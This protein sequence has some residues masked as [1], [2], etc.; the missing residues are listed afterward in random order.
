MQMNC[1]RRCL[2]FCDIYFSWKSAEA[3]QVKTATFQMDESG[4]H[5]KDKKATFA[6]GKPQNRSHC[7]TQAFQ[8]PGVNCMY[9][10][11]GRSHLKQVK[12]MRRL[13]L[14]KKGTFFTHKEFV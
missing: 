2:V 1:I 10:S 4:V 11:E 9:D 14:Q 3:P 13:L 6:T 7:S 12:H 8:G 5:N